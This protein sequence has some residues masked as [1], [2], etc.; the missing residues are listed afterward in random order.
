MR[1]LMSQHRASP[2]C[3][4]C[5][6]L[7]DPI[8][9]ALENFDAV[10]AWRTS[11]A[12]GAIDASAELPDGTKVDGVAGL[13][14]AIV[15]RPDVFTTT[16]TEKLLTYGIGRGLTYRDMPVVRSIVREAAA[17]Q[18]RFSSIVLGIVRSRP[19]QMKM[20]EGQAVGPT[21]DTGRR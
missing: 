17:H 4:A 14:D 13:R 18:Y 6:R 1:E 10:G 7:M 19:F 11:E 5:H 3:A 9:F 16:V 20:A 8:G 21:G 12:G 15:R 2:A